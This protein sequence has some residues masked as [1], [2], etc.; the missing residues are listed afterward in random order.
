MTV[1]SPRRH[2]EPDAALLR[3]ARHAALI[4]RLGGTETCAQD[5]TGQASL[6]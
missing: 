4:P 3:R 1:N 6:A 5:V 2:E